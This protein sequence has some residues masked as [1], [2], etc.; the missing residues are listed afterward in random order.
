VLDPI[1]NAGLDLGV[2][3]GWRVED[4]ETFGMPHRERGS[5]AAKGVKIL[6]RE[7]PLDEFVFWALVAQPAAPARIHARSNCPRG[8]MP[9]FR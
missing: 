2:A 7:L 3:A 5:R 4:L 6:R 8:V 9:R 1:S